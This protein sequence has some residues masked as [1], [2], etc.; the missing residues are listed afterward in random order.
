MKSE[1]RSRIIGVTGL[2]ASDNPY[3]GIPVA[4]CLREGGYDGTLVGLTY[5]PLCSGVYRRDLLDGVH[6]VPFPSE[7]STPLLARLLE[8]RRSIGLEAVIP[9]L[10]SEIAT[11]ARIAPIL[12]EAGVRTLLPDESDVKRRGKVALPDLCRDRGVAHPRTEVLSGAGQIDH[13]LGSYRFPVVIKGSIADARIARSAD[14]AKQ[15]FH[16]LMDAWGYPLLL[17]EYLQGDEY[18]LAQICDRPGHVLGAVAM[19][20]FGVT[21]KGKGF[22]G[23]TVDEPD[24]HEIGKRLA[25]ALR[26]VGGME[27]ELLREASSGRFV[28]LEINARFPAWIAFA[29][30]SGANL[31]MALLRLLFDRPVGPVRTPPPGRLFFRTTRLA[32]R[33]ATDLASLI[34][35]GRVSETLP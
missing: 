26:W 7:G 31:P 12:R 32:I 17:Q 24:L 9:T 13:F 15:H 16:D 8:L 2:E 1:W 3:P 18:N 29:A 14:Q 11:Y 6:L 33:P 34:V 25:E 10:D 21:A 35:R 20:K 28:V 23:V 30:A 5:S 27:V 22:A 19:R 4:R